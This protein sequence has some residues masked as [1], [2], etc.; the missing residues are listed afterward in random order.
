M[1]TLIATAE[2]LQRSMK[3]GYVLALLQEKKSVSEIAGRAELSASTVRA[4][5]KKFQSEGKLPLEE[6][7]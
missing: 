6:T 4:W 5:K 7:K 1:K 2:D 3:K